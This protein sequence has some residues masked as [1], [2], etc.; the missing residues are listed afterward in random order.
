MRQVILCSTCKYSADSKTGPDG[1][2]GG[3]TLIGH[4]RAAASNA[5]FGEV[6]ILTQACLWNCTKPCSVIFRDTRRFSYVTGGHEPSME[7]AEAILQWFVLH[8]Q[9]EEGEVPFR[10]WPQRMRG[11]FIARIPRSEN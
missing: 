9:T 10:A 5:T 7:Q 4:V 8:G 6:E 1:R 3:E 2:T 11:H